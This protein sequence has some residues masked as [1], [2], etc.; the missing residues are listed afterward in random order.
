MKKLL[1]AGSLVSLLLTLTLMM[2][3]QAI[4]ELKQ[5]HQAKPVASALPDSP[6]KIN[7]PQNTNATDASV[8]VA[9]VVSVEV[10][11][12]LENGE[13]VV[14]DDFF[15]PQAER[16]RSSIYYIEEPH[17][18]EYL[19]SFQGVKPKELAKFKSLRRSLIDLGVDANAVDEL[20]SDFIRNNESLDSIIKLFESTVSE[21]DQSKPEQYSQN[22]KNAVFAY[23]GQVEQLDL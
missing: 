1:L 5:P 10:V 6:T 8:V 18:Q 9:P 7:P 20:T 15:G 21:K 3:T 11:P 22:L 14:E 12:F 13:E 2:S 16:N 4:P 17:R 19:Y 23:L